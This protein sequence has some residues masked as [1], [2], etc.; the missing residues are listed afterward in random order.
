MNCP[1]CNRNN[2]V[3][4]SICPSC[5]AMIYDSVREELKDKISPIVR[6][7][8]LDKKPFVPKTF[9][10][11][12][13][14]IEENEAPKI[15]KP[16]VP[17]IAAK[18]QRAPAP[19]ERTETMEISV[20]PT[21]P[22]L[23]EFR[24]EKATVPEW[25]LH[26][27]NAVQQRQNRGDIE[28]QSASQTRLVTN[29]A[30]ALKTET[31]IEPPPVFHEN[32]TVNSALQRIEQSRRQFLK[33]EPPI[34]QPFF[35]DAPEAKSFPYRIATK[36][37]ETLHDTEKTRPAKI[38]IT[39]KP[40]GAATLRSDTNELDTNK[41]PKI[42]ARVSARFQ[43]EQTEIEETEL[44]LTDAEGFVGEETDLEE[45][46]DLAPFAMRFN[47]G[48]FDLIIGSFV[49]LLLLIPFMIKSESWFTSGGLIAFA[50]TCAVVMFIYLT[51]SV[52]IYGRTFGMRIFALEVIDIEGEEYP[53]IHQA[54]V[55]ACVYLFSV[56]LGGIGFLTLPFNENRRAVHDLLS[57][58]VVV[59]EI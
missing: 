39:L 31:K 44:T 32:P 41:L 43:E 10:V 38:N 58:T 21:V 45:A 53:T 14:A 22:T 29:G 27:Q 26:L 40:K 49:S 2:A 48:L 11:Q 5:G 50:A 56:A 9:E 57:R 15:P 7:A 17:L 6:P 1:V 18:P 54:A 42:P 33:E 51:V 24:Y 13:A 4:L 16:E 35:A 19:P 8:F 30:T 36:N 34:E 20:K 55:S 37:G 23:V 46:D 52:A 12:A 28:T 59:R 3:T 25:R 47:S